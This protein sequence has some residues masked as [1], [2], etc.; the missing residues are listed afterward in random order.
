MPSPGV[1]IL[2]CQILNSDSNPSVAIF[3]SISRLLECAR[4]CCTSR[5]QTADV[6]FIS[7][8]D[9]TRRSPKKWLFPEPRPPHTP[10]YLA[11]F[12]NG[13]NAL[14]TWILRIDNVV[15]NTRYGLR[16]P[17]AGKIRG[18]ILHQREPARDFRHQAHC[19]D[20]V[21]DLELGLED[22]AV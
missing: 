10:L 20:R 9:A 17:V 5:M 3:F 15:L 21:G 7:T 2:S 4:L 12:S 6:P 19:R 16:W 8:H 18:C 22:A 11:G 1:S 14:A 13:W